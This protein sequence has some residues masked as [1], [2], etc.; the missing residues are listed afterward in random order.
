MPKLP[1]C[2]YCG[3]RFLYSEVR[4][5]QNKKTGTC[6]HCEKP[7]CVG[8][9]AR[10]MILYAVSTLLLV[11]LN[12]SLLKIPSMNLTYLLAATVLGVAAVRLLVPYTVRFFPERPARSDSAG[13]GKNS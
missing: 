3:A 12:L 5:S 10:R 9:G 4:R 11:G 2:P 8:G 1:L 13:N 6:P 7:F